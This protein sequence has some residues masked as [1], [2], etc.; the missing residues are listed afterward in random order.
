VHPFGG[1]SG[2]SLYQT[3]P[4]QA[5]L[6]TYIKIGMKTVDHSRF[7]VPFDF[8]PLLKKIRSRQANAEIVGVAEK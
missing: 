3:D 8:P 2:I 7:R 4:K 1:E 6:F 5:V